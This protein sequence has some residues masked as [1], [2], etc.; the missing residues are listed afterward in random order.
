MKKIWKMRRDSEAVSPVIA[1]ILMVAITVVLAAVLYVMVMGFGGPAAQ[2]PTGSFVGTPQNQTSGYK[3]TFGVISPDT[4]WVD[5][6][7][8]ITVGGESGTA[9]SLTSLSNVALAT[10]SGKAYTATITDLAGDGK[11]SNGDWVLVKATGGFPTDTEI[12][13]TLIYTSTGGQ[14]CSQT[15][16]TP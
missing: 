4:K 10:I 2:T 3:L 12:T 15:W 14:I 11:I 1:T 7:L 16:T 6:K 9:A 5:C 8:L 13:L